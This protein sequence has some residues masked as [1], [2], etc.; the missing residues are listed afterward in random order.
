MRNGF[1]RGHALGNDYLVM[2][3]AELDFRLTPENVRAICDRHTGV[4]SDGILVPMES[5]KASFGL[6]IWNPDGTTAEKSGNGLRIFARWLHATRRTRRTDFTVETGGGVVRIELHTDRWG[7]ASRATVEMGEATFRPKALPCT[8]AVEELLEQPVEVGKRKLRFTGVSVG[9][10][11]CV[12][13][14][15]KG[16]EWTRDELLEIGPALATHEIVPRGT[17]VQLAVPKGPRSLFLRIWERGAGETTASG[18][19]ACAAA[20]AA[21]RL[22]LVKSPVTV[23][24]PGGE[25][26]V[27]VDRSFA[28][29]LHGPV[30]EVARGRLSPSFLRTLR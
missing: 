1:F 30:E 21:V 8:L 27:A 7:E 17:N 4:G 28:L 20:A 11:H 26:E 24:S 13:F 9:N 18:S 6:V 16:E 29:T 3:P 2:D 5:R 23:E 22:G 15:A 10:P 19:S 12:V 14:R 25:L